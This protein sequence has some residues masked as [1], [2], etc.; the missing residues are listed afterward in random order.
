MPHPLLG[1]VAP[2]APLLIPVGE[3]VMWAVFLALCLGCVYLVKALLG[4]AAGV[5]GKIPVVGGWIDSGLTSVEQKAV[6]WLAQGAAHADAQMGAALHELARVVDWLGEEIRR[7][8]N[9]IE[10]LA[11]VLG[12]SAGVALLSRVEGSLVRRIGGVEATVVG[13]LRRLGVAEDRLARGIGADVL[14][15]IRSL[16]RELAHVIEPEVD[17]LRAR[18]RELEDG[19]LRT[20]RWIKAHPNALASAAFAGAVAWALARLG[21][22]WTR[23][24]NWNKIGKHVCGLP[25]NL[26]ED[27]LGLS[28]ALLAVVDPVAIAEAAITT[29]DA[30]GGIVEKVATLHDQAG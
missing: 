15:R 17:A 27:V 14:P 7:H 5:L 21:A 12:G 25:T 2:L 29:E 4:N 11:G 28:L 23:C 24:N 6:S 22:G 13:A 20:F 16:D 1:E 9:L 26:I 10:L 18:A 19:A 30:I 3:I 8:A